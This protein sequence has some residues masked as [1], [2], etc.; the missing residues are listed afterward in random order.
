MRACVFW[1][2]VEGV[3]SARRRARPRPSPAGAI[4]NILVM[5]ILVEQLLPVLQSCHMG[6][7]LIHQKRRRAIQCLFIYLFPHKHL[8]RPES[9]QATRCKKAKE[10]VAPVGQ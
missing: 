3:L 5:G 4:S 9:C 8:A 7:A 1:Q 2:R 10:R 6:R